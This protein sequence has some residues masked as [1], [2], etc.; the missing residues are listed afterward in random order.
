MSEDSV[1]EWSPSSLGHACMDQSFCGRKL[2]RG[3]S[4]LT[5]S[6]FWGETVTLDWDLEDKEPH[7]LGH[8]PLE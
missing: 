7:L 6:S 4:F 2:G 8:T 3:K 1:G 5:T